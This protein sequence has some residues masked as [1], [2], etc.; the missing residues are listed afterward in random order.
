MHS[1]YQAI[2]DSAQE[3]NAT[4]WPQHLAWSSPSSSLGHGHAAASSLAATTTKSPV[5]VILPPTHKYP[6]LDRVL[7]LARKAF[8]DLSLNILD[9]NLRFAWV[10]GDEL[11]DDAVTPPSNSNPAVEPLPV[12]SAMPAIPT[13]R[14]D[15]HPAPN[16]SLPNS[17][18]SYPAAT[19]S[20]KPVPVLHQSPPVLV[21]VPTPAPACASA[22]KVR[23]KEA[24]LTC[25]R[26]FLTDLSPTLTDAEIFAICP[27]D[28]KIIGATFY[29]A[30]P[31]GPK[32]SLVRSATLA[33]AKAKHA[34][35]YL[36]WI[37]Q[38]SSTGLLAGKAAAN[39]VSTYF[40]AQG[41]SPEDMMDDKKKAAFYGGDADLPFALDA[42][43]LT[44]VPRTS[45][46]PDDLPEADDGC[47]RFIVG[48]LIGSLTK[49][50]IL[51][52]IVPQGITLAGATIRDPK[53][54]GDGRPEIVR[55]I[56]LAFQSEVDANACHAWIKKQA[57]PGGWVARIVIPTGKIALHMPCRPSVISDAAAQAQVVDTSSK[58]ATATASPI[59]LTLSQLF[60]ANLRQADSTAPYRLRVGNL[61]EHLSKEEMLAG[62]IPPGISP[63]GM[64]LMPQ[65]QLSG[66]TE[67]CSF[68]LFEFFSERDVQVTHDWIRAEALPGGRVARLMPPN[69]KIIA[70]VYKPA[71]GSSRTFLI[72]CSAT[73]SLAS[74]LTL[75]CWYSSVSHQIRA[76]LEPRHVSVDWPE[77]KQPP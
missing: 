38:E 47:W 69:V 70:C 72:L 44:V 50:Q 61:N 76:Q 52:N 29:P 55:D 34:K 31:I 23:I 41:M 74:L 63:V 49:K 14:I 56:K 19:E 53:P 21:P 45:G 1:Y 54:L 66:R 67:K 30:R 62:L 73:H 59:Q 12:M 25:F 57:E 46:V 77:H 4:M 20:L 35:E 60:A 3:A 18:V 9:L 51:A 39:V 71:P 28:I 8:D 5:L 37:K 40:L 24:E 68:V 27:D 7:K 26:V 48:N 15:A 32:K 13:P 58:T 10:S 16:L 65:E 2:A 6:D 22:G 17:S 42:A 43:S 36:D 64:S 33:F 75:S 11:V